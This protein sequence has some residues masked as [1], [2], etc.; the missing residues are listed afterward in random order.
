MARTRK[1]KAGPVV[2]AVAG[3]APGPTPPV[4]QRYRTPRKDAGKRGRALLRQGF[5]AEQR[6]NVDAENVAV[7]VQARRRQQAEA[8]ALRP[9]PGSRGA[10]DLTEQ[11]LWLPIGPTVVLGGQASGMPRVSG[12]MNDVHVS[13]D[14]RRAYAA[15]ANGGVW[16]TDDAG[17]TWR[18][19]GGWTTTAPPGTPPA[20]DRPSSVLT[21]GCMLVRFDPGG[22]LAQDEVLVGT[23]EL[24][25]AVN[26]PPFGK[27]SGIG[28]LYG[29]HP[30][31]A[32]L[33]GS[34]WQREGNNLSGKGIFRLARDPASPARLDA[35]TVV[36]ASSAGFWTRSGAPNAA[37]TAVP[38][39]RFRQLDGLTPLAGPDDALSCTDV[40][41]LAGGVVFVAIRNMAAADPALY[42][43]TAGLAG[44]F[45]PIVLPGLAQV[46]PTTGAHV[47]SRL[48]LAPA[49]SDATVMYV[50]AS[51]NLVWRLDNRVPVAVENIPPN[52]LGGQDTYNQAIAVH[53]TRPGRLLLGGATEQVDGVYSASLYL[54]NVTAPAAGRWRYGFAATAAGDDPTADDA[55]IGG[56]VHADVHIARFVSVGTRNELWVGCDGGIFRSL[57]GNDDNTLVNRS[58]IA[59][60]TGLATL[61]CG[62][63]AT[64]PAVDGFVIAGAQDNGL[65]ERIGVN[66]WRRRFEHGDAGSVVFDPAEPSRYVAQVYKAT[67][68]STD[69]VFTQP[70][71]RPGATT[72]AEKAEDDE[73]AFYTGIDAVRV[74]VPGLPDAPGSSRL[75]LG[76]TRIWFSADWG[77]TWRTLRSLGDPMA[78]ALPLQNNDTDACVDDG[79]T[80]P[81]RNKV[82]GRVHAVR[83]A[84]PERLYVLCRR[85][86]L[87]YELIADASVAGGLRVT[88]V[89]LTKQDPAKKEDP[90]AAA[91]VL[92][93]GQRLPEI[94]EWSDIAAHD[95][96]RGPHGSFYVSGT[97]DPA[98]PEMDTVWWFDGSSRW[99]ATGLRTDPDHPE[100]RVPAPAYALVVDKRNNRDTVYVGTAVGVWRGVFDAAATKWTWAPM[101]N[102][103]PEVFVH[104]LHLHDEAAT[105]QRLLRAAIHARGVWEVD[106]A[107]P[108]LQARSFVRVH[109][110]DTRRSNPT[111]L[112]DPRSAV[113]NSA[114]SWHASPD[115]RVRP[116]RGSRLPAATVKPT[117][118]APWVG[119]TP[120]AYGLWVFQTALHARGAGDPLVKPDGVWTPVFEAR[121]RA[122]N[123]NSNRL[124]RAFWNSV[125]GSGGSFPDAYADPWNG[126]VPSEADLYELI[127]DLPKPGG[128]P[129]SIAIGRVNARVDVQVHHRHSDTLPADQVRVTLLARDISGTDAD[130]SA[131]AALPCA[132]TGPVQVALR[133][134]GALPAF[135]SLPALADG[136]RFADSTQPVRNPSGPLDPRLSRVVSFDVDLGAMLGPPQVPA[137]PRRLMLVAVIHTQADPVDMTGGNLRPVVL[138]NRWVTARSLE[139]VRVT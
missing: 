93:P 8:N 59:R 55:F 30:G 39:A 110:F 118:T 125:V 130:D 63:V 73:T 20:I 38:A 108:S 34:P 65:L 123:G 137:V 53:P 26:G 88:K 23:G 92:T 74:P 78:K 40:C 16:Y 103:L 12:R 89:A 82:R 112:T 138:A 128:S 61:Q 10:P 22:D 75:A 31:T 111:P 27:N 29:D 14:G 113:P 72:V 114:L 83:W 57:R 41:W 58:F 115:L 64:H 98:K 91:S 133:A 107:Q 36:A 15:S 119:N 44:P 79:A 9:R 45:M 47:P 56:G 100:R 109:D 77:A 136:W 80:P 87:K 17:D 105:G 42:V 70:V 51:G 76:T 60:N 32:P 66:L 101:S 11:H 71:S 139:V 102:G 33:F 13:S 134:G 106:L 124:T 95:N 69:A 21:C 50:L 120:D 135:G 129:A 127:V 4:R 99:H 46:H 54:A 84:S 18:P 96:S 3:P 132:W 126:S 48:S 86:V 117:T 85:E 68:N 25:P 121:L 116:R 90:Q 2:A 24:L 67:W 49:P 104:D 52:L 37:W 97:G 19:L 122:A 62:Y 7:A 1:P 81:V 43:S 28:V 94:G 131:W 6:G 35:A 5:L